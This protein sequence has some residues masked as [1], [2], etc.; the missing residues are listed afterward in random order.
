LDEAKKRAAV[1]LLELTWS[2]W[3]PLSG[4]LEFFIFLEGDGEE[5][6]LLCFLFREKPMYFAIS[7]PL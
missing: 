7:F 2:D 1:L 4:P 6:W 3:R 5:D